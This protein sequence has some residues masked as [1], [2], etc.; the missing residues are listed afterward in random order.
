MVNCVDKFFPQRQF[1]LATAAMFLRNMLN[2]EL[3]R[4]D[5]SG[6]TALHE[7]VMI[8][9][10]SNQEYSTLL[11]LINSFVER[12]QGALS[13]KKNDARLPQMIHLL[14]FSVPSRLC[15]GT[16]FH[17]LCALSILTEA[18]KNLIKHLITVMSKE[19]LLILDNKE[20]IPLFSLLRVADLSNPDWVVE[21]IEAYF[22]KVP[23]ILNLQ[24][25]N[26]AGFLH[27]LF[28]RPRLFYTADPQFFF[29]LVELVINKKPEL[30]SVSTGFGDSALESTGDT[31]LELFLMAHSQ[32]MI[33]A[34]DPAQVE[35]GKELIL[36]IASFSPLH[37]LK[38]ER[39]LGHCEVLFGVGLREKVKDISLKP[40]VMALVLANRRLAGCSKVGL[41]AGQKK[42]PLI[43]LTLWEQEIFPAA[44]ALIRGP[45]R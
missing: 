31:P 15:N 13:I 35:L 19:A 7:M 3:M 30:F 14:G 25:N 6:R 23:E 21:L 32:E 40:N 45:K 36:R 42:Q 2:E 9:C 11:L 17:F 24:F 1:Y 39:V 44:Q 37:I 8:E 34:L 27:Y 5:Y 20:E 12:A 26:R 18:R 10:A 41:F 29:K 33:S 28:S 43:P 16:P 4:L 22:N 38:S